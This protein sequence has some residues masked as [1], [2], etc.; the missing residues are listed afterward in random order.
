MSGKALRKRAGEPL[1]PK[2]GGQHASMQSLPS[3]VLYGS[4]RSETDPE[5]R[6]ENK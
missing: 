2:V 4:D 6:Q 5:D 1:A 3:Y